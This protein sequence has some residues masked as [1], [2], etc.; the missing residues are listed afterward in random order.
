MAIVAQQKLDWTAYRA[1]RSAV[2]DAVGGS[3]RAPIHIDLSAVTAMEPAG[4]GALVVLSEFAAR[5][6]RTLVLD[7]VDPRFDALLRGCGLDLA[8]G[9]RAP[10]LM[11]V[12]QSP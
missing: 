3:D 12:T 7:G 4:I 1:L 5:N 6:R 11:T 9:A 2:A 8:G 10:H